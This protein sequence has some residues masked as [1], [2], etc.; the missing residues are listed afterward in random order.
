MTQA[1]Q[2][3]QYGANN[4][5]LSFKNRIIN[6]DMSISQRGT[7]FSSPSSYTLD[8]WSAAVSTPASCTVTQSSVA[9][10]GFTNSL[11]LTV[12]TGGTVGS[13]ANFLFQ[14]IEGFNV[15]DLGWGT[16]NAQTVT[17]SF[18]VRSS[19]VG[20]FS[21]SLRNDGT[22]GFRAYPFSYTIT[23]ANTWEQ[24]SVTIPGDT[25]GTWA[26][27]NGG[28]IY[29]FFDL[30]SGAAR[31]TAGSWQAGNLIGAT[32]SQTALMT[33]N[34]ATWYVTG[35]Q[36]EKGSVATS[37]D[38]L[39]YGTELMLCQ[40]YYE[41]S[42]GID[43]VPGSFNVASNWNGVGGQAYPRAITEFKVDK[44]ATPT[45]VIY[46]D[47]DGTTGNVN[48]WNNG[49][50]LKVVASNIFI[51]TK[52]IGPEGDYNITLSTRASMYYNWTVSAEL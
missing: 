35:V 1:A 7:S 25:S 9:P 19:I 48:I 31:G 2:L 37:F 46:A 5:G 40:R 18:W 52:F 49:T 44:R 47:S 24:K 51:T 16:A 29:L 50:V 43:V 15:A 34:G 8:R 3:A 13:A 36:L 39:P 38:Y 4:V 28:G 11:A 32:G 22:G 42:Y 10:A 45:L 26:T 27:N 30:G 12:T 17:V 23:T 6:G 41:K 33:T 21:G 20:T 14:A